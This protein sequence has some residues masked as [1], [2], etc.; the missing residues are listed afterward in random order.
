MA[1][2]TTK[3]T[4]TKKEK[5]T[6]TDSDL[7][8]IGDN[9]EITPSSQPFQYSNEYLKADPKKLVKLLAMYN[10]GNSEQAISEIVE[11]FTHLIYGGRKSFAQMI[12]EKVDIQMDL[13]NARIEEEYRI[14]V[15]RIAEQKQEE[16]RQFELAARQTASSFA[17]W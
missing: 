7:V 17:N 2:T 16:R 3:K 12:V 5:P 1:K 6:L 15:S 13:E 9:G 8:L 10:E 14:E 11:A 4:T